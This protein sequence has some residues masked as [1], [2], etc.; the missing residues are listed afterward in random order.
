MLLLLEIL[1]FDM[2]NKGY[3]NTSN[4]AVV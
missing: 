3:G 1:E 2:Y 4:E